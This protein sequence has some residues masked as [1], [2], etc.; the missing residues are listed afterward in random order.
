MTSRA[1]AGGKPVSRRRADGATSKGAFGRAVKDAYGDTCAMTGL[2]IINGGGRSEVQAAH[3]RAVAAD[4]PDSVRNG[5][6]LSSTLHWM[7]DRGLVSVGDDVRILLAGNA[8][9]DA[10]RGMLPPDGRLHV[11]EAEAP[12][13]HPAFF[14]YHRRHVFHG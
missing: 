3:I 12:R 9:P 11:P 13:P 5:I 4:G 7:F 1:A 6:A 2:R 14:E 8:I 10:I